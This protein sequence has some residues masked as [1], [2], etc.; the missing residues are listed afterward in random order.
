M[1]NRATREKAIMKRVGRE[2]FSLGVSILFAQ[3][4]V[5]HGEVDGQ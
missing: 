2:K 5:G 4:V 3:G 1:I